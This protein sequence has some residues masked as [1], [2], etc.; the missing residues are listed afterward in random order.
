MTLISRTTAVALAALCLAPALAA[1]APGSGSA[2]ALP[3]HLI[4]QLWPERELSPV[5]QEL[6]DRVVRMQDSVATF[7]A[8][9][10]LLLRQ[11]RGNASAGVLRSAVRSLGNECARMGRNGKEMASFAATLRTDNE[12]WGETAVRAFR[13]ALTGLDQA[14]AR[15]DAA[16]IRHRDAETM[17][18]ERASAD[19]SAAADAVVAYERAEKGLLNT[20]KIRVDPRA[21]RAPS[22]H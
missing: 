10:A 13:D 15:C 8:S 17:D 5:E 22:P 6:K 11:R 20:L 4:G 19:A 21:S 9:H 7:H 3:P 1:Q 14:M 2:N 18:R 12:R 16:M